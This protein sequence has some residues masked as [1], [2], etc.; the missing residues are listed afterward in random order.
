[1]IRLSKKARAVVIAAAIAVGA[2]ASAAPVADGATVNSCPAYPL[3][4]PF[5]PWLDVGS[6]FLAPGGQF[7]GSLT[8]WTVA[9]GGKLINGNESYNRNAK[10]DKQS[11]SLPSGSSATSPSVCVTTT[12]PDLRLF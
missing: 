5:T 6:Y 10:T 1:M 2:V 3:V 11:L 7:E 4:Q 8:G 9:G 12:T